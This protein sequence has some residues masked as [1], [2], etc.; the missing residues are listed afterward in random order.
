MIVLGSQWMFPIPMGFIV[1]ASPSFVG[2]TFALFYIVFGGHISKKLIKDL[3]PLI[4]VSLLPIAFSAVFGF[5]R[6][7]FAQLGSFH[8][9]LISPLWVG[10][11]L[12]FKFLAT[13]LVDM[14][15]NPDAAPYLMFC[16]DAVAAMAGN[17]LF[18]STSDFSVVFVMVFLDVMENLV[19]G[20]RVVFLILK[21]RSIAPERHS[22]PTQSGRYSTSAVHMEAED[23]LVKAM[24]ASPF[25]LWAEKLLFHVFE[26]L[27]P[28][29]FTAVPVELMQDE[30]RTGMMNIYLARAARLLVKFTASE[31]SEMLTSWW[32]IAMLPFYY[33]GP[34][35]PFMYTIDILDEEAFWDK[36]IYSLTD[37]A[38][39]IITFT[40]LVHLFHSHVNITVFG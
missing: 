14:G 11:K 16:F 40:S 34:N 30:D 32:C 7:L 8:Q 9:P 23:N 12:G 10:I 35:K 26:L 2:A 37:F 20:L 17:F 24:Q 13:K 29:Q 27:E 15:N 4:A 36:I 1:C 33:Y 39:E 31:M 22:A 5:Y 25:V 28:K 19:V 6:T 3:L 21:S 18:L 38:L